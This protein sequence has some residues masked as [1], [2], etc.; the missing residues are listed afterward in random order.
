[1]SCTASSSSSSYSFNVKFVIFKNA[2]ISEIKKHQTVSV[3]V[4]E[5]PHLDITI[6]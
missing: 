4:Y 1:M 3:Y 2:K 5:A 6:A